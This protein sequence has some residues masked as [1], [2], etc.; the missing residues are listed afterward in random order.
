VLTVDTTVVVRLI[1]NDSPREARR[2]ATL[3]ASKKIFLPATVLLETEWVLRY[4]YALDPPT[5]ATS[6]RRLL[7]LPNVTVADPL[8]L[9]RALQLYEEGLDF[10]DALQL[11]GGNGAT[12][13]R[14]L[15]PQLVKRARAA[16]VRGVSM[17]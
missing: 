5:I 1:T 3:F 10:A 16:G 9:N 17:L 2:A 11:A 15:D 7:G 12:E 14:T 8:H 6:L 4:A 13:M